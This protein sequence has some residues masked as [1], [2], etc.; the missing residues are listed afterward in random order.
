MPNETLNKL[1]N[2]I[3]ESL[4]DEG[5]VNI[6]HF[7]QDISLKRNELKNSGNKELARMA[8]YLFPWALEILF[9]TSLICCDNKNNIKNNFSQ[10]LGV[11]KKIAIWQLKFQKSLTYDR[12]FYKNNYIRYIQKDIIDNSLFDMFRHNYYFNFNEE[13]KKHFISRFKTS[14]NRFVEFALLY[15]VSIEFCLT[16]KLEKIIF[17]YSDVIKQLSI[18]VCISRDDL[19][20]R[21]NNDILK[22]PFIRT[23]SDLN[24]NPIV[25]IS[26]YFYCP[27]YFKTLSSSGDILMYKLTRPNQELHNFFG[28]EPREAYLYDILK[29]NQTYEMILKESDFDNPECGAPDVALIHN[30]KLLFLDSKSK[31]SPLNAINFDT[32]TILDQ[33]NYIGKNIKQIYN[34]IIE[35]TKSNH[36][37]KKVL[38]TFHKN[39]IYGIV[40]LR[41]LPFIKYDLFFNKAFE[42][43]GISN[44]KEMKWIKRHIAIFDINNIERLAFRKIELLDFLLFTENMTVN[45]KGLNKRSI[46]TVKDKNDILYDKFLSFK[47]EKYSQ[48]INIYNR[49]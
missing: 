14:Y 15:N 41:E 43:L 48:V 28:K 1:V 21:V 5:I 22:L 3:V 11:L 12:F 13:T 42:L 45:N 6:I 47:N 25:E 35:A 20:R 8:K 23:E 30:D 49:L 24:T 16:E 10:L 40:V 18:N 2:D 38:G 33:I 46:K 36:Q 32:D 26:N 31:S 9:K 39:N 27:L 34:H 7:C 19:F 37:Y 4:K 17:F 44:L 29:D